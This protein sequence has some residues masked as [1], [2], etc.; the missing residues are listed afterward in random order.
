[1]VYA[2]SN[3][4]GDSGPS[5]NLLLASNTHQSDHILFKRTEILRFELWLWLVLIIFHPY[6][7]IQR[8]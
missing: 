3:L 5:P 6:L 7:T 4:V 1:M 2:Q 8:F